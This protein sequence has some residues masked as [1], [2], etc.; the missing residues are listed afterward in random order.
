M[1]N[2]TEDLKNRDLS[3]ASRIKSS[4]PKE[5]WFIQRGDGTI[6]ACEEME[7]WEILNNRSTWKRHDFK[8]IGTSSGETYQ[9]V[10]AESGAKA[11]EIENEMGRLRSEQARYRA[12]EERMMFEDL[13]DPNDEDPKTEVEREKL[14]KV[15]EIINK[16]DKDLDK[17]EDEYR[18][19]T[20]EI[21][22]AAFN[23]ELEVAKLAP[24]RPTNQA[25]LT[26]GASPD[27]R[28]R[29]LRAMGQGI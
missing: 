24:R 18:K 7:A 19:L 20:T 26:P 11:R 2:Q 28:A 29:I 12:T 9:R 4:K 17:L 23:A 22:T 8:I 13:V 27:E 16:Y 1:D 10:M 6:F 15:K 5:T 3:E 14:K 21:G 25:I